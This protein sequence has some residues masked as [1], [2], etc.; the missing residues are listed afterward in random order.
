MKIAVPGFPQSRPCPYSTTYCHTETYS[1]MYADTHTLSLVHTSIYSESWQIIIQGKAKKCL[2]TAFSKF[3]TASSKATTSKSEF[4]IVKRLDA[5]F[6]SRG[7]WNCVQSFRCEM[8]GSNQRYHPGIP[9]DF[10]GFHAISRY[11]RLVLANNHGAQ[12]TSFHGL[13]FYGYDYRISKL[14]EPLKLAEYED[15]LFENVSSGFLFKFK[16]I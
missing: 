1:D 9:K 16:K 14:L 10:D 7:P 5:C 4:P 15:D 3:P 11:W 12:V 13:E 2:A 8:I 6:V